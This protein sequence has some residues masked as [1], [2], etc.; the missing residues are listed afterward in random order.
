M[1]KHFGSLRVRL[2]RCPSIP[3]FNLTLDIA[4]QVLVK[5]A[6]D[7]P[8]LSLS[9]PA[10]APCVGPVAG[11]DRLPR[12]LRC[13]T[14]FDFLGHGFFSFS[15]PLLAGH[16]RASGACSPGQGLLFWRGRKI[17]LVRLIF[18]RSQNPEGPAQ[19]GKQKP[20]VPQARR[21]RPRLAV[22]ARRRGVRKGTKAW[23]S[24]QTVGDQVD[25]RGL[26]GWVG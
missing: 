6:V 19:A 26:I 20:A 15:A 4:D 5:I 25:A 16:P 3:V 7:L 2:A 10:R 11:L 18:R 13:L 17:S 23:K 1:P 22:P 8:S 21:S 9:A 14:R 24:R 12:L